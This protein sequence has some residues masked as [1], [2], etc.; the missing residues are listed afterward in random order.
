MK[1]IRIVVKP[2]TIDRAQTIGDVQVTNQA[3][4]TPVV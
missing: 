4:L 1:L 2:Y 3:I